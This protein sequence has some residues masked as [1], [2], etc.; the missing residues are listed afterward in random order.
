MTSSTAWSPVAW[1]AT[2]MRD[3]GVALGVVQE[4]AQRMTQ[5]ANILTK[6]GI[7]FATIFSF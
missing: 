7:F 4:V 5:E 1:T 6:W 2:S 3:A